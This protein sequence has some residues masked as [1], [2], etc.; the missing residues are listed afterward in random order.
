[1]VALLHHGPI[2]ATVP[3]WPLRSAIGRCGWIKLGQQAP[4]LLAD[5]PIARIDNPRRGCSTIVLANRIGSWF[6][7][8]CSSR[9]RSR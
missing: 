7:V 6:V 3:A 5:F 4:G 2:S 1:M 8:G 9:E